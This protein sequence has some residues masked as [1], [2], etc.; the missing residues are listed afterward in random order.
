M[1]IVDLRRTLHSRH[2]FPSQTYQTGCKFLQDRPTSEHRYGG[3]KEVRRDLPLFQSSGAVAS[4][5]MDGYHKDTFYQHPHEQPSSSTFQSYHATKHLSVISPP[6][7]IYQPA[8]SLFA[9][10]R[11]RTE[12]LIKLEPHIKS[13]IQACQSASAG[14]G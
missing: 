4:R 2:R 6:F 10:L 7:S 12:A 1:Q 13:H 9:P 3:S 11:S 14:Q 8:P 5:W